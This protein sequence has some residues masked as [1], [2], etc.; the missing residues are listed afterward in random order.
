VKTDNIDFILKFPA[1]TRR[2]SGAG[3]DPASPRHQA[4][5]Q[6]FAGISINED[7]TGASPT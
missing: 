3:R 4:W 1:G 5:V 6:Q 7:V 2:G